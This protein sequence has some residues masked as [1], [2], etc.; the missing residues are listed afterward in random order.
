MPESCLILKTIISY[1]LYVFFCSNLTWEQLRST[2][3]KKS[4][5]VLFIGL[6]WKSWFATT[7]HRYNFPKNWGNSSRDARRACFSPLWIAL[8]GRFSL[9]ADLAHHARLYWSR[10]NKQLLITLIYCRCIIL[11]LYSYVY[12]NFSSILNNS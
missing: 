6:M 11:C 8:V 1:N 5:Y 12:V 4:K 2:T 7:I 10:I 9:P 3:N